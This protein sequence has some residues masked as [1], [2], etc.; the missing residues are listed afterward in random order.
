MRIMCLVVLLAVVSACAVPPRDM[1]PAPRIPTMTASIPEDLVVPL[2]SEPQK[3]TPKAVT[4]TVTPTVTT[5][6]TTPPTATPTAPPSVPA[7]A[8]TKVFKNCGEVK[9]A[10]KGP[11]RRG[12]PGWAD[13][14]DHDGDGVACFPRGR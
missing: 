13:W 7:V 10:G 4:S 9:A 11:I 6:G 3:V 5:T 2:P 8:K 12:D 1:T 14:L